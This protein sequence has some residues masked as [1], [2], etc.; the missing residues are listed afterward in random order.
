[1]L[2]KK[3]KYKKRPH[4]IKQPLSMGYLRPV[5]EK[6]KEIFWTFI[7]YIMTYFLDLYFK[8]TYFLDCTCKKITPKSG[9]L[10]CFD[11]PVFFLFNFSR[12]NSQIV[13]FNPNLGNDKKTI[14]WSVYKASP[15]RSS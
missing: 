15:S 9:F 2:N 6:F 4:F 3:I 1:M 12:L 5:Y 13:F 8:V 11:V 10:S 7:I 14:V